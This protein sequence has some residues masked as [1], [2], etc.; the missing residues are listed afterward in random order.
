MANH[1][2][3]CGCTFDNGKQVVDKVR[4]KG[5]ADEK[6][7]VQHEITCVCTTQ[8]TMETYVAKCPVCSMTYGVTPC[9]CEDINKVA[10]AD[11]NY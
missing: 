9:S 5:M 4:S 8:F 11:I 6:M 3:G 10:M 1:D 2:G 7:P